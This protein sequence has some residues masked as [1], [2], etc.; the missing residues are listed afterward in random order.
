[1]KEMEKKARL[2]IDE[3]TYE[4]PIIT[5]TYGAGTNTLKY[6]EDYNFDSGCFTGKYHGP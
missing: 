4:L 5:G 6:F 1:V 3:K 2:I